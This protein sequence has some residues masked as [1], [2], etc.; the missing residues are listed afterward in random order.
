MS[1]ISNQLNDSKKIDEQILGIFP[2][3]IG[4]E[5]SKSS[6]YKLWICLCM[7]FFILNLKKSSDSM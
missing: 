4:E 3:N 7:Y 1:L 2:G 6:S 5:W